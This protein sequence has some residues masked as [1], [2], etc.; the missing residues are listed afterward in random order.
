LAQMYCCFKREPHP[1]CSMLKEIA[2]AD[3]V[4]VK[5]FTGI[6]TSPKDTVREPIERAAMTAPY[7]KVESLKMLWFYFR[8]PVQDYVLTRANHATGRRS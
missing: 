2:F 5:S 1:L 7:H 3:W 6:A 4:A 8:K